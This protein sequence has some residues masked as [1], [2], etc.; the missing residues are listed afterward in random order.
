MLNLVVSDAY[1]WSQPYLRYV[2]SLSG[3]GRLVSDFSLCLPIWVRIFNLQRCSSGRGDPGGENKRGLSLWYPWKSN[4]AVH[5]W[6]RAIEGFSWCLRDFLLTAS[7]SSRL[8]SSSE[9]LLHGWTWAVYSSRRSRTGP[10]HW[11]ITSV[12]IHSQN[13]ER[14][15]K[16]DDIYWISSSNLWHCFCWFSHLF[17]PFWWLAA[18]YIVVL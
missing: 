3:R 8:S 1:K 4:V 2:I 16:I 6:E 14:K 17:W 15:W 7:H 18:V 11:R 12:E 9:S 13:W 10:A 5:V